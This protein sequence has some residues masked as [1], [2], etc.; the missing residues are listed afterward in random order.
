MTQSDK[1]WGNL[2]KLLKKYIQFIWDQ[3]YLWIYH[4]LLLCR[5][6]ETPI[7]KIMWQVLQAVN[8]CHGHNVSSSTGWAHL[9]YNLFIKIFNL[10]LSEYPNRN[11]LAFFCKSFYTLRFQIICCRSNGITKVPRTRQTLFGRLNCPFGHTHFLI[12]AIWQEG[13]TDFFLP[14]CNGLLW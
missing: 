14:K 9:K 5:L 2:G 13:L 8:F 6:E 12:L 7:K 10:W 4:N 3:F 11:K 1:I